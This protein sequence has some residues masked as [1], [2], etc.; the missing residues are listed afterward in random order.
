MPRII[1]VAKAQDAFDRAAPQ[2]RARLVGGEG[3]SL[4]RRRC[5]RHSAPQQAE[6]E[7]AA[8]NDGTTCRG[9]ADDEGT[10]TLSPPGIEVSG[11]ETFVAA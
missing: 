7:K 10:L 5:Q 2:C 1:D 6:V 8:L 11:A 9:E 4:R 3:R